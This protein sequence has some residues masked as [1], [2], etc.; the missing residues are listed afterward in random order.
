MRATKTALVAPCVVVALLA[1]PMPGQAG[2]TRADEGSTTTATN[3][4]FLTGPADGAPEDLAVAFLQQAAADYGVTAA[5]VADL[6]VRS[7]YRSRHNGVTHVNVFQ[8]FEDKEVFGATATVNV[9]ADGSIVHVG[10]TLVADLAPAPGSPAVDSP[11][12]AVEAAAEALDL[13]DPEDLEPVAAARAAG[14]EVTL[15]D[16]GI[17]DAPIPTRLGWQ[18]TEDGLRPAYQVVIDDAT[19]VHLYNAVVDAETG[20][21]L[22]VDDWTIEHDQH[23][24][25][26]TLARG[27][28]E[29]EGDAHAA[30]H[31]DEH[32]DEPAPSTHG[33]N[34]P[35]DDGSS[36]RVYEIPKES[37]NDGPRTLVSSPADGIASPFGWHDTDGVAGPEHTTTRGN[38][39]HAY[40]DRDNDNQPDPGRDVDGGPSLTF[41]QPLDLSQSPLT[42]QDAAVSNLFYMNNVIHDVMHLYGFDEQA[43]N[44][45][46]NNLGRGGAGGDPVRAEAQDGGGV[47]NANMSTPAADGLPARMQ[48]YL[49]NPGGGVLPNQVVVDQPSPAAGTYGATGASFGPTLTGPVTGAFALGQDASGTLEA[50]GPLVGFPAGAVAIVDRGTCPFADK[51]LNAQAAGASAVV[52]ANNAAG[53]PIAIGGTAPGATI[54]S[55]M[56]SQADGATLK[57]GLPAT[58]AVRPNPDAP[59][60]RDGDLEN[61][62]IIHEYGHGISLR[63]TGGPGI[64]CLTGQ[65][66]MGEGWSDYY[67][68]TMLLD[69]ALDDPEGPR[70][71]GPY[72]VYQDSREGNGI[73]P[74]PYSRD[75]EIQPFT[76]DRITTNGWITGGSLATPHGVGHGWAATLWDMNWDLIER[77]GFND[78]IYDAWDAGGNNRALQYVTDGLKM[79]GCAPG[80]V[81][82]RD[83]ILAAAEALGGEDT[84]LIWSSFARRGL[85]Y[86]AVQGTTGR[87]DNTEAFDVPAWCAAPG[88][89]FSVMRAQSG[90][91][92]LLTRDAG[93]AVPMEFSLGGN[94]GLDVLKPSHSPASQ[95]IDCETRQAL[96]YAI[97]TPTQIEDGS[98]L[99]YNRARD[100][101]TYLWDTDEEWAGTCRQMIL[102]L[103]DGT[104]HRVDMRFVQQD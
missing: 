55:V 59:P 3:P 93:A 17:S 79:Q 100:R 50:C 94:L 90:D 37:P 78:N 52:V 91:A 86:S 89:G 7:S 8:R 9:A 12:E 82:G 61:G 69:P 70:G 1:V 56:V 24:L 102:T 28:G 95:Q 67:A 76:Y 36:Y 34:D 16:G 71:M 99:R 85:G 98:Q 64:N 92:D 65:E 11:A 87:D 22:E 46:V 27:G 33:T 83:G 4:G 54:P 20:E 44:F 53:A 49:W 66:Q 29:A 38:N 32:G 39:V 30:E 84:C 18:P 23:V 68:I 31:G 80:F 73:R 77:H 88:G 25:E 74:R 104:Q 57:A 42:Y 58:G 75:M 41:D 43:G 72:A 10:D 15:T 81:A 63:L 2:T 14:T 97:T 6:E 19:D 40:L 96:Q 103:E 5:D 48:M 62:I 101:Y 13:E 45:Q 35:V 26:S 51:V 21:L 60:Q 47:N